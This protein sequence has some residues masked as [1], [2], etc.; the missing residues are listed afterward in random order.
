MGRRVAISILSVALVGVFTLLTPQSADAQGAAAA[1]KANPDFINSFAKD[2]GATPE[3]AAGAAGSLFGV[4]KSQLKP[5]QFSQ[6]ANAVPGMD[7]MLAAAPALG[8][9]GGTTGGGMKG[10][11]AMFAKLGLKPEHLTKAIPALTALVT[12][13][14]GDSVGKLLASVLK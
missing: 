11:A 6:I 10:V 2:I 9:L 5:D 1:L 7:A 3:Q 12:K 13:S 4:A 8:A 14:G